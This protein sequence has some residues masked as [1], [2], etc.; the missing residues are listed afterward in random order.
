MERAAWR[1]LHLAWTLGQVW[2]AGGARG[3]RD[4]WGSASLCA[5]YAGGAAGILVAC[6]GLIGFV[7]DSAALRWISAFA[8]LACWRR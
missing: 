2:T 1:C 8:L 6:R 4:G 7:L 5:K 3:V